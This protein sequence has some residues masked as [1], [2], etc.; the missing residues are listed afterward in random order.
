MDSTG[1]FSIVCQDIIDGLYE[2][3]HI[4]HDED[5]FKYWDDINDHISS[6]GARRVQRSAIPRT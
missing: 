3:N 4:S 1:V 5:T 6:S 2:T